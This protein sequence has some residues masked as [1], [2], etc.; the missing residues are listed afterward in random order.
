MKKIIISFI[1]LLIC[2]IAA[3]IIGF[4]H[5]PPD[6]YAL[7]HTKISGFDN[8]VYLPDTIMWRWE[9]L[10][11]T[12]FTLYKFNL[13]PYKTELTSPVKGSLFPSGNDYAAALGEDFD[14]SFEIT[15]RIEF[16]INPEKLLMLVE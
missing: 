11:P 13:L 12:V 3:L 2:G 4:I 7:I 15:M 8:K 10:L 5:I 1:I 14:F 16:A 9:K 6:Y